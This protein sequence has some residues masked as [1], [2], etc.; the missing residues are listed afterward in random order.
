MFQPVFA[1]E[2]PGLTPEERM[3]LLCAINAVRAGVFTFDVAFL[4]DKQTTAPPRL[5]GTH[6]MA[7]PCDGKGKM[8]VGVMVAAPSN[9]AGEVYLRV[10]DTARGNGAQGAQWTSVKLSGI[11]GFQVRGVRPGPLASASHG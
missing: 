2:A 6:Y 1:I 3:R 5:A 7:L 4:Y 10:V 8:H 9:K 11:K